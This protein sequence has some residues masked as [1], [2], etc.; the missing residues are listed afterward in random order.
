LGVQVFF[1]KTG[2]K[3]MTGGNKL[4]ELLGKKNLNQRI[5]RFKTMDERLKLYSL[6][7][8]AADYVMLETVDSGF[9]I[10]DKDNEYF[11]LNVRMADHIA[12]LGYHDPKYQPKKEEK[13]PAPE[14][15]PE[16]KKPDE[17]SED[18]L[19]TLEEIFKRGDNI[20]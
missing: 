5:K 2:K 20:K 19:P 15:E 14:P 7:K 4:H 9:E 3:K 18:E 10:P 17:E 13:V 1:L 16:V 12:T 8:A 11:A 6:L